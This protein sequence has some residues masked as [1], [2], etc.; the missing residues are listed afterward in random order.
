[1]GAMM[2]G[3]D[4]STYAASQYA[5]TVVTYSG[6]TPPPRESEGLP[7]RYDPDDPSTYPHSPSPRPVVFDQQLKLPYATSFSSTEVPSV[8]GFSEGSKGAS[9]SGVAEV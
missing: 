9:Y 5:T 3:K 8:Q 2:G 7:R 6:P 1:M 4:K